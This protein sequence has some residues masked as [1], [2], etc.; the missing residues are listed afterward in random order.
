M[1][2]KRYLGPLRAVLSVVGVL[3]LCYGVY[4]G[5]TLPEPPPNSD[6]VPTGFAVIY[7]LLVQSAGALLAQV[8]YALPAGTGRFRFGPLAD[9]PAVV[10]AAAA[11]ALFVTA[12]ALVTAFGWVLPESVP[13][14][15]SGT[16]A[17]LWFA[18]V[19]GSA[20]GVVLTAVLAVGT[21]L[22]RLVQGEPVLDG[23]VDG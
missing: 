12:V 13:R 8:G 9:S 16:H 6:G 18:A 5:A 21:A 23:A 4:F 3:I 1:S 19:A 20:V 2:P 22:W 7:V 11:T 10:R 15:V 14:V 17:F